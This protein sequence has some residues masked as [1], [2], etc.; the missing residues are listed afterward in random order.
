M[1]LSF[2]K[3]LLIFVVDFCMI[4]LTGRI[5]TLV[6]WNYPASSSEGLK[7]VVTSCNV[8]ISMRYIYFNTF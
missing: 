3:A 2:R 4:E 5:A 6:L 8:F 1:I 7:I